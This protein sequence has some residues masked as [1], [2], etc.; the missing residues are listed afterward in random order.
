M[1]PLLAFP[2]GVF[3]DILTCWLELKSV[4]KLDTA[5]CT[6][7]HRA[8]FLEMCQEKVMVFSLTPPLKTN[9]SKTLFNQWIVAKKVKI[10]RVEF[11]FHEWIEVFG[12]SRYEYSDRD[13]CFDLLSLTGMHLKQL[14]IPS[15]TVFSEVGLLCSNLT[16]ISINHYCR[17]KPTFRAVIAGCP[18][19]ESLEFDAYC[20]LYDEA[21]W[22]D[23][24]VCHKLT[25]FKGR[26]ASNL[27]ENVII[28]LS[29]S[30]PNLTSLQI[31]AGYISDLALQ[32]LINASIKLSTLE[33]GSYHS[34]FF[35]ISQCCSTLTSLYLTGENSIIYV[36]ITLFHCVSLYM[37]VIFLIGNYYGVK[38]QP[39]VQRLKNCPKLRILTMKTMNLAD[40]PE[41]CLSTIADELHLLT[42]LELFYCQNYTDAGLRAIAASCVHLTVFNI[43]NQKNDKITQ[44]PL[45]Q[46]AQNCSA[47]REFTVNNIP[48]VSDALLH[49][50]AVSCPFLNKC[51]FFLCPLISDNGV[52]FLA[53]FCERLTE[54]AVSKNITDISLFAIAQHCANLQKLDLRECNCDSYH[55]VNSKI[56]KEGVAAVVYKCAK[57][58]ILNL[59]LS[60]CSQVQTVKNQWAADFPLLKVSWYAPLFL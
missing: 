45:I 44:D 53:Q 48:T 26:Y 56:T 9:N 4:C 57:L 55:N 16:H 12:F 23:G 1:F 47:L 32:V 36:F 7:K 37:I 49:A 24:I 60:V 50:L 29:R 31:D 14:T 22:F 2:S 11:P 54:I 19:L 33:V 58:K 20:F 35:Q 6:T 17:V 8:R 52:C 59:Q 38:D 5:F 21:D 13:I 25:T 43:T 28:A 15:E 39:L 46:I 10:S 42:K 34:S 27:A 30:A 51:S 18:M 40:R 3:E 41:L